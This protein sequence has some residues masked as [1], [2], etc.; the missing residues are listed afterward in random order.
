MIGHSDTPNLARMT[1]KTPVSAGIPCSWASPNDQLLVG[2]PWLV[3]MLVGLFVIQTQKRK[4]GKT[5]TRQNS[6]R[7]TQHAPGAY[8]HAFNMQQPKAHLTV[9]FDF[10]AARK[11]DYQYA[12]MSHFPVVLT[13]GTL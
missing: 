12:T 2:L 1:S 6:G 3:G 13:V 9:W 11:P 10:P 7:T 4:N 8:L 5:E